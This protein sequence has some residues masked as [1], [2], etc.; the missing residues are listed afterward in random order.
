MQKL[1]RPIIFGLVLVAALFS[2]VSNK[3]VIYMQELEESLGPL[4]ESSDRYGYQTEDYL[5][6]VNDIVEVSIKTTDP[7]LNKVFNVVV[8]ENNNMAQMGGSQ[9]AG[10][11][12]FMNGYTLDDQGMVE[13]PLVGELKFLGLTT[14]EAK[15]LVESKVVKYVKED[16]Y[17]VR[18]RLGGVRFSALGE[19]NQS[20]KYT[21]LQNRVT[22]FEAIAFAGDLS[23]LA[24]RDE[25]LLVRQYPDGSQIHKINL[26]D[27]E[28]LGSEYYFLKPNDMIYAEPMK[29]REIGAGN[30]L[31]ETLTLFTTTVTA[32]AL[33]LTLIQ[34]N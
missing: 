12:F 16:E 15:E 23:R 7:E 9:G 26:L 2:C 31:V 14:R 22:I 4:V 8:A 34:N 18:V 13:I 20:G 21:I 17:F 25:V 6:Q 10:D 1:I 5:L 3:K 24:K 32:I 11:A 28:L 29:V 19:F 27:R 33:I 30:T